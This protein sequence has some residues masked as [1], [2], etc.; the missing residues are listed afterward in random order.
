MYISR[1]LSYKLALKSEHDSAVEHLGV[2]IG[3]KHSKCFIR[4]VDNP[5]GRKCL[6][7]IF[8]ALDMVSVSFESIILCGDFNVELHLNDP[9]D[10][11]FVKNG[12]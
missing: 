7:D 3:G 6:D 4:C 2:E 11:L 12:L 9:N 10:N 1:C 5:H 8:R